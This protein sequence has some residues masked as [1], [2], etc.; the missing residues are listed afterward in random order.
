MPGGGHI[1]KNYIYR[2]LGIWIATVVVSWFPVLDIV[3]WAHLQNSFSNFF[4]V[5]VERCL[6]V[7]P[8]SPEI[9]HEVSNIGLNA[10]VQKVALYSRHA[11][12]WLTR[13]YINT[14]NPAIWLCFWQRNLSKRSTAEQILIDEWHSNLGPGARS[15]SLNCLNL[16]VNQKSMCLF[17][18]TLGKAIPNQRQFGHFWR[19][20][21]SH[22]SANII[23][24]IECTT[25]K[26]I[27]ISS[28]Y[29]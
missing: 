4:A 13:D 22:L 23:A 19:F 3:G 11:S 5:P 26:V 18:V 6:G 12:R 10:G 9:T 15:I 27:M 24:V 28:S 20:D 8:A 2:S 17:M 16:V 7:W 14:K 21:I 25:E 1:T 29:L